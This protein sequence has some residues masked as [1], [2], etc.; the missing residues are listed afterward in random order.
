[1]PVIAFAAAI[2]AAPACKK[3]KA[4][5]PEPA[6]SPAA[7]AAPSPTAVPAAASIKDALAAD[8]KGQ[9]VVIHLDAKGRLAASGADGASTRVLADGPF[10]WGML[11]P[12]L[13]LVWVA[14]DG[15]L[16]VV[17]LR[18]ETAAARAIAKIPS[19]ARIDV[20]WDLG[21]K[22]GVTDRPSF[23]EPVGLI[24]LEWGKFIAFERIDEDDDDDEGGGE[25]G[26]EEAKA[27]ATFIDRA[28]LE[29]QKIRAV[30]EQPPPAWMT[31]SRKV[32]L[33]KEIDC[34]DEACGTA[35]PFGASGSEL[36]L[37]GFDLGG[38]CRHFACHVRTSDGKLS[39]P[40]GAATEDEAG[41]LAAGS[42]GPFD[43]EDGGKQY[44]AG[45]E[46]CAVGGGCRALGGAALGWLSGGNLVGPP[47]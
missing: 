37:T 13:D 9:P 5:E 43:F 2:A 11:E 6:A 44:L 28:W 24:T 29:A 32:T 40:P 26:G 25:G 12:A 41:S 8:A 34:K 35:V 39:A 23:C 38:D 22:K 46:V 18:A 21:G 7:T 19:G 14:T 31:P 30:N 33:P 16:V 1:V 17:D 47:L 20:S 15:E 3:E 4:K 27:A 45:D 10:E 36:V 42:C